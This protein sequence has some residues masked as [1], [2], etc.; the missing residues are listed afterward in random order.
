M[1]RKALPQRWA[2]GLIVLL[3]IFSSGCESE[4][5]F[6]QA[7]N[8]SVYSDPGG[9]TVTSSSGA[10]AEKTVCDP[11][12][13]SDPVDT[14]VR[15]GI[16]ANLK[17]LS[18]EMPRYTKAT[19]YQ[20]YGLPVDVDLFFSKLD[21]PT[22]PFDRGFV[23]QNGTVLKNQNGTTLYEYFSIHFESL[24]QLSETDRS[25]RYQFALLS[26][27]GAVLRLNLG[28]GY[29]TI[30]NNDGTHPS[31]FAC[32]DT[33][34]E[35]DSF[36]QIP[37]SLDY[38]QGPRYHI[39]LI[40]LWREWSDDADFDWRDPACNTSGNSRFFNYNN[41]PPTP[42]QI[43]Q[44]ILARGWKVLNPSNFILPDEVRSNPCTNQV[45]LT[46]TI[47]EVNPDSSFTNQDNITFKF[48]SNNV[49]ASFECSLDQSTYVNCSSPT[50]YSGLGEGAHHFQVRAIDGTTVD[51]VGAVHEWTIDQTAP[52][53]ISINT[54]I[55]STSA[56]I[57]WG[58]DEPTTTALAWGLG[59]T[60]PSQ[61]ADDGNPQVSHSV[62][63]TGLT[64]NTVYSYLIQGKDRAGN[65]IIFPRRVFRTAP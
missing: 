7:G 63:L 61:I 52:I 59:S 49:Q 51:E 64:P 17:Y 30:V 27:D 13:G 46:T 11:F 43:Y 65:E 35:F 19:D 42:T 20:S 24:L 57:E 40:L 37:M 38:Y 55:G 18:D 4:E 33:P 25:T 41:N 62:T 50:N 9:T 32:A 58:T 23:T 1:L 56:V 6:V 2:F 39:S 36:T 60:T 44:D 5:E 21:I 28:N 45:A 8:S 15:H 14:D 29:Q 34:I 47:S 12:S 26:D 16:I 3:I 31:K 22:R 10:E 54:N 48:V 53:V